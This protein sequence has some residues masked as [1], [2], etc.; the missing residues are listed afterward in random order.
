MSEIC[1]SCR[2]SRCPSLSPRT[3]L[4]TVSQCWLMRK[5]PCRF[6]VRPH[7]G[8]WRPSIIIHFVWPRFIDICT[9]WVFDCW[10]RCSCDVIYRNDRSEIGWITCSLPSRTVMS[11]HQLYCVIDVAFWYHGMCN[12]NLLFINVIRTIS[13]RCGACCS[14]KTWPEAFVY[15]R[16]LSHLV[17]FRSVSLNVYIPSS[18]FVLL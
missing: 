3:S 8:L 4:E 10:L 14:W 18:W 16:L 17:I 6:R 15:C 1:Y 9:S 12:E 7:C 11:L 5:V 2:L 13:L